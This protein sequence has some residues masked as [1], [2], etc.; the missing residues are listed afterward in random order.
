MVLKACFLV[1]ETFHSGEELA[2]LA[3][4]LSLHQADRDHLY[5]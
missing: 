3:V 2:G 5:L 1:T 4:G